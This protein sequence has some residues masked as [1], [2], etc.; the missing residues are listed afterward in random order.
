M[1]VAAQRGS[2]GKRRTAPLTGGRWQMHRGEPTSADHEAYC[3]R[4]HS[5]ATD[6]RLCAERRW[7]ALVVGN[8]QNIP[9]GAAATELY[10]QGAG[11]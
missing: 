11:G 4:A 9:F 8:A 2:V 3:P 6:R 5:Q 10:Q 1:T 7:L